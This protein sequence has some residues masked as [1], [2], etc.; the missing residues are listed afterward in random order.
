MTTQFLSRVERIDR[1]TLNIGDQDIK[2]APGSYNLRDSIKHTLPNFAPFTTT[3]KRKSIVSSDITPAPGTYEI[4]SN[5]FNNVKHD[6]SSTSFRSKSDRFRSNTTDDTPAAVPS[7]PTKNQAFGY[8]E[9]NIG[10]LIP[11]APLIAGFSGLKSDSVGPG[12][13]EPKV[14]PTVKSAR[15]VSFGKFTTRENGFG[16][17]LRDT[18]S[19]PGPGQYNTLSSFDLIDS[20]NQHSINK[21]NNDVNFIYQLNKAKKKQMSVFESKTIRDPLKSTSDLPGPGSYVLP[22]AIEIQ[23]A[24]PPDQQTFSSYGPRFRD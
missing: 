6:P 11:Q 14:A 15:Q 18:S 22:S 5:D 3:S 23:R 10:T 13:Y 16:Y 21:V 4:Y 1:N 2:A 9:D 12:D 17:F 8:E 20:N 24:L 7:I 19:A